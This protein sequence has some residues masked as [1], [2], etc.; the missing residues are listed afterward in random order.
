M[1]LAGYDHLLRAADRLRWDDADVDVAADAPAWRALDPGLRTRL[2]R[3]VA[4]FCVAEAAVAEHLAPF[5]AAATDPALAA[6]F[7]AQAD[8]EA[9]HARFFHRVASETAEIGFEP[10]G[11]A[12]DRSRVLRDLAGPAL[13]DLFERE[14]P[15]RAAAVAAGGPLAHGVGLYHL[16]LEGVV[17]MAGQKALLD[18]L[19]RAGTLP[20]VLDGARRVQADERWHLGLGVQ[21]L[22]TLGADA[23]A[24]DLDGALALAERCWDVAD[25]DLPAILARHRRRLDLVTDARR[26]RSKVVAIG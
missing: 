17:F 11:A 21:A 18:A 20:R 15:A 14:L 12:A 26:V 8:D 1:T 9:R 23:A 5:A 4:G 6:C 22:R 19:E 10:R 25:V 16:I 13:V 2:D 7:A 24:L 3:L